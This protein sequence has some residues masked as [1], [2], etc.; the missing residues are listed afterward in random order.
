[1]ITIVPAHEAVLRRGLSPRQGYS[2]AVPRLARGSS[3]GS[4][5]VIGGGF[6]IDG[7][8]GGA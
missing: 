2:Q 3:C 7:P 4:M 5:L 6:S 1:M 8:C